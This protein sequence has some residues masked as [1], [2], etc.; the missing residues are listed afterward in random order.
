[1][2][3]RKTTAIGTVGERGQLFTVYEN[4]WNCAECGQEN[5]ASRPRCLRCKKQKPA[6]VQAQNLVQDPAL[7]ALQSG[8]AVLWQEVVDPASH[9]M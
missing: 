6:G 2:A 7:L 1:M 5:Y 8:E 3:L 9:Q 4:N